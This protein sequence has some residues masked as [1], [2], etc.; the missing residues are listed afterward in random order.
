[1]RGLH[2]SFGSEH[3]RLSAP[4]N[5]HIAEV[6]KFGS[7]PSSAEIKGPYLIIVLE[8]VIHALSLIKGP[9]FFKKYVYVQ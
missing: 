8:G 3:A 1:M 4:A 2:G 6:N 5:D 9:F 7:A